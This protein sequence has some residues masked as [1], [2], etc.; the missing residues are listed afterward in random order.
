MN[1]TVDLFHSRRTSYAEC[2]YWLR[3]ERVSVGNVNEW[4]LKHSPSGTFYAKEESPRFNSENRVNSSSFDKNTITLSC[5][6]DISDIKRGCIVLYNG[7]TWFVE[8]VQGEPHRKEC[9][10][11][12]DI[13]YKYYVSLR[14]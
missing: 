12:V 11:S 3:D 13:D 5:D 2:I 14:R 10:F 4:I 7:K 9:E 8:S 1:G 6:D